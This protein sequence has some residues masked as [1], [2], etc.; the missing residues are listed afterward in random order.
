MIFHILTLLYTLFS[1]LFPL[2]YCVFVQC[3]FAKIKVTPGNNISRLNASHVCVCLN[4]FY[5]ANFYSLVYCIKLNVFRSSLHSLNLNYFGRLHLLG[6][7]RIC[8]NIVNKLTWLEMQLWNAMLNYFIS[9]IIHLCLLRKSI[10][11]S[12]DILS[13]WSCWERIQIQHFSLV[14]TDKCLPGG[15]SN[16]CKAAY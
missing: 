16:I 12:L 7:W 6:E 15:V 10:H 8:V 13:K 1:C 9:L 2:I 14:G 3:I 4:F 5:L 11:G